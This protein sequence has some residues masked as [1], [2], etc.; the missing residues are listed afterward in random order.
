MWGQCIQRAPGPNKDALS[1]M[2]FVPWYPLSP[3]PRLTPS[4]EAF[5]LATHIHLVKVDSKKWHCPLGHKELFMALLM[6]RW[7]QMFWEQVCY[8]GWASLCLNPCPFS[9]AAFCCYNGAVLWALNVSEVR[10]HIWLSRSWSVFS[11]CL[12]LFKNRTQENFAR[13]LQTRKD[14]E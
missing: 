3:A 8:C 9:W 1:A 11:V 4:C 13:Q 5:K 6:I 14:T 2:G 7:K 10:R 12:S